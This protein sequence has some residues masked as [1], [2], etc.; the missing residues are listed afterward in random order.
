MTFPWL[1]LTLF[2]LLSAVG[3]YL[4]A[5]HFRGP[6]LAIPLALG[7]LALFVL[8]ALGVELLMRQSG[9]P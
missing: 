3:S 6:R 5:A 7:V 1:L 2:A 9:L 8:L 4:I